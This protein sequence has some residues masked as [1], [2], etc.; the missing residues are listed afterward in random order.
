MIFTLGLCCAAVH[1]EHSPPF[2]NQ[3]SPWPPPHLDPFRRTASFEPH[4]FLL[5]GTVNSSNF[6]QPGCENCVIVKPAVSNE[7][8]SKVRILE[9][10][11]R[12]A[13]AATYRKSCHIC[14]I[15]ERKEI[16]HNQRLLPIIR[17]CRTPITPAAVV[18]PLPAIEET[19]AISDA[20]P[21]APLPSTV[22]PAIKSSIQERD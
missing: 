17:T 13:W 12:L 16:Q 9:A 15:I 22:D 21:A 18:L 6:A 11:K 3:K 5:P 4:P 1:P 8:E 19:A 7:K 14:M 10:D 2:Q 20:R